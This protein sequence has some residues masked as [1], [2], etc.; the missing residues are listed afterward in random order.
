M[1]IPP[2]YLKHNA[3]A[4]RTTENEIQSLQPCS[5]QAYSAPAA[6]AAFLELTNLIPASRPGTGQGSSLPW[7]LLSKSLYGYLALSS[8]VTFLER[9]SLTTPVTFF[10][11][12]SSSSCHL[13]LSG[14]SIYLITLSISRLSPVECE[15]HESRVLTVWFTII[16]TQPGARN[17]CWWMNAFL[18]GQ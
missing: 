13:S 6:P 17:T 2:H 10:A 5:K 3:M 18:V 15:L 12:L 9:P 4:S 7:M 11:S 1:R 14:I 8:K 16:I